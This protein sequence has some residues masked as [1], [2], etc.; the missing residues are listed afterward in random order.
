MH[1]LL[2]AQLERRLGDLVEL[3]GES[4]GLLGRRAEVVVDQVGTAS[5][6]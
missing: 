2:C 6:G 4:T 1:D 5:L 3:A